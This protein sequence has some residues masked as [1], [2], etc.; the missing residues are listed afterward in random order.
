MS[1]LAEQLV[2]LLSKDDDFVEGA[3]LM[4]AVAAGA[5]LLLTKAADSDAAW[6]DMMAGIL[7]DLVVV[8]GRRPSAALR[9]LPQ[10]MCVA[11]EY[12]CHKFQKALAV[13]MEPFAVRSI[14]AAILLMAA[15][16][17]E[18]NAFRSLLQLFFVR[19]VDCMPSDV[20]ESSNATSAAVDLLLGRVQHAVARTVSQMLAEVQT[21]DGSGKEELVH[22][23][24]TDCAMFVVAYF[25][26][27][28]R[29]RSL[30]YD[31]LEELELTLVTNFLQ[32]L[33]VAR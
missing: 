10:L 8:T 30:Q 21:F 22:E 15:D 7:T 3:P 20:D 5:A 2:T 16:Y 4:D 1:M 24:N 11:V 19:L 25:V 12:G 31:H 18:T 13:L 32:R 23:G 9:L 27:F 26:N 17:R 14:S 28:L 29:S 33:F 6:E